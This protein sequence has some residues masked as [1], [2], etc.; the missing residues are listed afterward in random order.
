MKCY[1]M[2]QQSNDPKHTAK[3]VHQRFTNNGL[4]VLPWPSQSPDFII[5]EGLWAGLLKAVH[6][7]IHV[8]GWAKFQPKEAQDFLKYTSLSFVQKV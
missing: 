2:L 7:Q 3:S 6:A 8:D 1:W 5:I 4:K